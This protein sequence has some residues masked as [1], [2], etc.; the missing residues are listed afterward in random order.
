MKDIYRI[1]EVEHKTSNYDNILI[2]D[3]TNQV[4]FDEDAAVGLL[5]RKG[6][7]S[8]ENF[9]EFAI[10]TKLVDFLEKKEAPTPKKQQMMPPRYTNNKVRVREAFTMP[11]FKIHTIG[12]VPM[13]KIYIVVTVPTFKMQNVVPVASL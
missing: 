7:I 10:N 9:F 13:L 12:T 11:T 2:D 3:A 1:Y 5:D 6:F 4:E 8:R